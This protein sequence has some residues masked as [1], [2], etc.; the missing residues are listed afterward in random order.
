VES[1]ALERIQER[2]IQIAI[3]QEMPKLWQ[4]KDEYEDAKDAVFNYGK[5]C[6]KGKRSKKKTMW[7]AWTGSA[8]MEKH[9]MYIYEGEKRDDETR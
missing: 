9:V 2:R 7:Q 6:H 5:K 1:A 3:R 8:T 4:K